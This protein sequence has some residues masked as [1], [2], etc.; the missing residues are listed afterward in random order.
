M[1]PV[2]RHCRY[3]L[4][5]LS[6]CLA[7]RLVHTLS[8]QSDE[9]VTAIRDEMALE[10]AAEADA[11]ARGGL[12]V[13]AAPDARPSRSDLGNSSGA[14]DRHD[15]LEAMA[16]AKQPQPSAFELAVALANAADAKVW[17]GC[18]QSRFFFCCC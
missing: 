2:V 14:L 9:S 3:D 1:L 6:C 5:Y 18:G 17:T 12:L 4:I 15:G 10:A 7:L 8:R 13:D 11:D 16:E